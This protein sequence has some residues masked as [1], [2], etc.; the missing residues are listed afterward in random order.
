MGVGSQ[1]VSEVFLQNFVLH[2]WWI[3]HLSVGACGSLHTRTHAGTLPL[4]GDST[5]NY[6]RLLFLRT[7]FFYWNHRLFN[8]IFRRLNLRLDRLKIGFGHCWISKTSLELRMHLPIT[9]LGDENDL[10]NFNCGVLFSSS[11]FGN[12]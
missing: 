8:A 4:H 6:C 5:M 10:L 3:L 2:F 9:W 11:S 1:T 7:P 12:S